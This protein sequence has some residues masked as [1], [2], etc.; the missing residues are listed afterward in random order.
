LSVIFTI[1]QPRSNIFQLFDKLLLLSKG[2]VVYFGPC[3]N[4]VDYFAD[5]GYPIPLRVNPADFLLDLVNTDSSGGTKQAG[6]L[7]TKYA[8]S[9]LSGM[10]KEQINSILDTNVINIDYSNS[11]L[12]K[13][14]KPSYFLQFRV[15]VMRNF[16]ESFRNVSVIWAKLATSLLLA[17]IMGSTF[18]RLSKSQQAVQDRIN[19][20]FFV[21]VHLVLSAYTT[22]P[23]LIDQ[24]LLF[25]RERSSGAYSTVVYFLATTFSDIPLT[26]LNSVA[27]GAVAYFMVGFRPDLEHFG[28]FLLLLMLISMVAESL[29]GLVSAATP[30]FTVANA[31]ASGILAL[32]ILFGGFCVNVKNIAT[33]WKWVYWSSFFQYGFTAA[34]INEFSGLQFDCDSPP[35]AYPD[36]TAVLSNLGID[37]RNKWQCLYILASLSLG[38]RVLNY[39]VLRFLFKE[40]H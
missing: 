28:F 33:G 15:L 19:S 12:K 22:L 21:T 26:A 6:E 14:K 24:R 11:Y 3:A 34:V 4:V 8:E 1:H 10:N 23:R 13:T 5:I 29:C 17:L 30:S 36:G 9:D 38:L 16:L 2:G 35:C 31:S 7:A 27:F 37:D 25:N 18:F 39:M 20:L 40:K 32:F